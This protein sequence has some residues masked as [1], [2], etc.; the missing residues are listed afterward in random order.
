MLALAS[1]RELLTYRTKLKRAMIPG[2][3]RLDQLPVITAPQQPSSVRASDIFSAPAAAIKLPLNR[4]ATAN[5]V[6]SLTL[7]PLEPSQELI[8]RQGVESYVIRPR[9]DPPD[10]AHVVMRDGRERW[11][12]QEGHTRLAAAVLRGRVAPRCARV[13]V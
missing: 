9:R 3:A 11:I 7:A 12:I 5:A 10:V 6:Q 1:Q 8:P 2:L 13:G 4:K